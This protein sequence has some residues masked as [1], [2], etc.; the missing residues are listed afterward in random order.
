MNYVSIFEKKWLDLVF[1]GKN[2]AY[3]AYQLRRENPRTTMLALLFGL[4][5]LASV[6]SIGLLTARLNKTTPGITDIVDDIPTILTVNLTPPPPEKQSATPVTRVE[7]PEKNKRTIDKPT[8]VHPDEAPDVDYTKKPTTPV[9]P[10]GPTAIPGN[11]PT[12]GTPG[13]GTPG[14]IG[15]APVPPNNTPIAPGALDEMP[16]YPGGIKNFYKY[17]GNNFDKPEIDDVKTVTVIVMFVIEKD[18]SIT[19]IRVA[20][21]PGYGMAKEA[22][23]VL[24]SMKTKWKAGIKNGQPVRTA[25]SLPITVNIN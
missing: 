8:V 6:V 25:Y 18:G 11:N 5:L 19:D 13:S 10:A 22:T 1:E 14:G 7:E 23:R 16:E 24:K 15:T 3:G 9:T 21:D 17:I 20:R 12:P 4:L 2:K